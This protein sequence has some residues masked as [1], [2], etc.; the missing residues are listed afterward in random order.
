MNTKSNSIG[1]NKWSKDQSVEMAGQS[2]ESE[3]RITGWV[4]AD[5]ARAIETNGDP[6]FESE[7][8]FEEAWSSLS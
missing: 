8:G 3:S 2:G 7:E 4:R 5:G 1:I 6:V